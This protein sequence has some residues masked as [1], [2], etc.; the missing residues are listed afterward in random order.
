MNDAFFAPLS[1]PSGFGSYG[2]KSGFSGNKYYPGAAIGD[3]YGLQYKH[4]AAL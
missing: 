2:K 4:R 1:M 3:P